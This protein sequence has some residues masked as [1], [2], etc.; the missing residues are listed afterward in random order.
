MKKKIAILACITAILFVFTSYAVTK[1]NTTSGG[2]FN[3]D[4]PKKIRFGNADANKMAKELVLVDESGKEYYAVTNVL[5]SSSLAISPINGSK[6]KLKVKGT[7]N[8]SVSDYNGIIYL[9]NQ[10]NLD[11]IAKSIPIFYP[12]C[13]ENSLLKTDET[14]DEISENAKT[15]NDSDHSNTNVQTKGVD[16]ADIVKTDG[17]NIY[18]LKNGEVTIVS[19]NPSNMQILS[20]IQ[21]NFINDMYLD[22]GKLTLIYDNSSSNNSNAKV[23]YDDS[24]SEK[25]TIGVNIYNI[26]DA[27]NPK[28]ISTKTLDGFYNQSRKKANKLYISSYVDF[29]VKY[30]EP[31]YP[32]D[33]MLRT[34]SSNYMPKASKVTTTLP[35]N[36]IIYLP[37]TTS[38]G[39]TKIS[40]LNENT[41]GNGSAIMYM[42]NSDN[43]YMSLDN[44]YISSYSNDNQDNIYF[45]QKT[46][47]SKFALK[48][49]GK[50]DFEYKGSALIEG[51][52]LNQF[53]FNEK[54]GK[55]FVAY[56]INDWEQENKTENK[57][58]SFDE[59]MKKL[60]EVQNLALGERIYSVRY[61]KDKAYIVTF[62]QVDPLFVID[63]KNPQKMQIL[64]YLKVPGYSDYLHPFKDNYL[65]GFGYDTNQKNN[66]AVVNSGYKVSLFDISD[67][68]NPK[69]IDT[70][71][72]GKQGTYSPLSSDHKALM[73]DYNTNIFAFPVQVTDLVKKTYNG[74]TYEE[75]IPVFNGAYVFSVSEKGFN[76]KGKITHLNAKQQ[77]ESQ[78][79]IYDYDAQIQRAVQ[80]GNTIYTISDGGIKSTNMTSFKEVS[81]IKL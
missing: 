55:L 34:K 11:N 17:K 67:F 35:L 43:L 4:S 3:F 57:L 32:N 51:S 33:D 1:N 13:Y 16:E 41:S 26:S 23:K 7:D 49:N 40:A 31:P 14:K 65:I 24:Y 56:T 78:N 2:Y 39:V 66:G 6:S 58:A 60:S 79:H 44:I 12:V 61:M 9:Q 75:E 22:N 80:I 42:G 72:I 70:K 62:K 64:G 76:L 77:K 15:A 54:D 81:Y 50:K 46:T 20:K 25:R 48:N 5:D 21:L 30:P 52:P 68:K 59:N 29:D 38:F 37:F 27:K 47:I 63:I 53:S 74:D 19:A 10:T 8:Y 36:E 28:L 18:Y 73:F 45:S 71:V 69:Q